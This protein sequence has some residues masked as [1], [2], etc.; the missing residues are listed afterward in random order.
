MRAMRVLRL[1]VHAPSR[2]PVLVLGEVDGDRCVPVFL[3]GPQAQVISLEPVTRR[4][5]RH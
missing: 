3:R 5:S 2:Q 1:V 4:S